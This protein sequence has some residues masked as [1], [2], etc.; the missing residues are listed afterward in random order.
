MSVT[1]DN[2][3]LLRWVGGCWC[4]SV[5]YGELLCAIVM[6]FFY[7]PFS[8]LLTIYKEIVSVCDDVIFFLLRDGDDGGDVGWNVGFQTGKWPRHGRRKFTR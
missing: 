2:L 3:F 5:F 8:S 1:F 6:I 4:E 7:S